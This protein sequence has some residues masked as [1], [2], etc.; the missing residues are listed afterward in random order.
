MPRRFSSRSH[1]IRKP[2]GPYRLILLSVI[3]LTEG[4]ATKRCLTH[5]PGVA[6]VLQRHSMPRQKRSA[7]A[8]PLLAAAGVFLRLPLASRP[9]LRFT[10]RVFPWDPGWD[11]RS[12][13][14]RP[15]TA[16]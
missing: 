3:R 5:G 4:S 10:V 8:R 15:S 1:S 7:D 9:E 11:A 14:W 16:T 13:R 12:L 6:A 2:F